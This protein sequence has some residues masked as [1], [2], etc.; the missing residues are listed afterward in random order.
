MMLMP[1]DSAYQLTVKKLRNL[2][3]RISNVLGNGAG[4]NTL[5]IGP[6]MQLSGHMKIVK[7]FLFSKNHLPIC[8][9]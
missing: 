3:C 9:V 1:I 5:R 2:A 7:S 8:F 6:Y 4:P